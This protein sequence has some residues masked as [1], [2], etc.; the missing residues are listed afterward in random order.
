MIGVMTYRRSSR[1]CGSRG[2]GRARVIRSYGGGIP[3]SRIIPSR[4][5]R[6]I[7]PWILIGIFRIRM[8]LPRMHRLPRFLRGGISRV[9]RR[10][11]GIIVGVM[12]PLR[13]IVRV[14]IW[15]VSVRWTG[16]R[17][18]RSG[19]RIISIIRFATWKFKI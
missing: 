2:G 6:R 1:R 17:R 5:F 9:V 12:R 4:G 8:F 19:R 15:I 10:I 11:M 18:R 7:P 13:I 3:L 14:V 16:G